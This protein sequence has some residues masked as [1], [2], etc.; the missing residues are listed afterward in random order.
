MRMSWHLPMLK[1]IRKVKKNNIS[2]GVITVA[3]MKNWKEVV[4]W[5]Q[6]GR[7]PPSVAMEA[8]EL[9]RE[10]C[11]VMHRFMRQALIGKDVEK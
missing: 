4:F 9:C 10:G 1:N 5:D 8:A 6:T 7:L 11:T 3:M 2:G